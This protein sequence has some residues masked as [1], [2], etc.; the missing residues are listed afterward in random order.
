MPLTSKGKKIMQ[1]MEQEYGKDA[2][3]VFYASRNKGTISGVDKLG[4]TLPKRKANKIHNK[5]SPY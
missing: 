3:K 5:N 1:A 2:E 4:S